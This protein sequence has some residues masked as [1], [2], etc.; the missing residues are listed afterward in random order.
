MALMFGHG[1]GAVGG[2]GG[3]LSATWPAAVGCGCGCV[4]ASTAASVS[5]GRMW[6][7]LGPALAPVVGHL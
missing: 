5:R 6:M 3:E 4:W 1:L 7:L 2:A